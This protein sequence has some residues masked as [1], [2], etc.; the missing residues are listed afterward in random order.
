MLYKTI[1]TYLNEQIINI[2]RAICGIVKQQIAQATL[3]EVS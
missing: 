2:L 3:A 1:Q